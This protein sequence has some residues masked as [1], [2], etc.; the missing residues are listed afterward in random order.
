[1]PK[2]LP[3]SSPQ[4]RVRL[5]RKLGNMVPSCNVEFVDDTRL[6]VTFRLKDARGR[7]RSNV[8][9]IHRNFTHTLESLS[10][11]RSIR[12]AGIPP[13]GFPRGLSGQMTDVTPN[14]SLERTREG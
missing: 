3:V 9:H 1:M 12:G 11:A 10:L 4:F 5:I 7:Y 8:V 2:S 6:G 14:K 13:G